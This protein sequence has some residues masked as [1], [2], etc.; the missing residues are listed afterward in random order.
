M[1]VVNLGLGFFDLAIGDLNILP[2]IQ[3]SKAFPK[4]MEDRK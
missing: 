1:D 4:L 2:G 3:G